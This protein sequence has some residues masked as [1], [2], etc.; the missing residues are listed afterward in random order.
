MRSLKI[1]LT[2]ACLSSLALLAAFW[3]RPVHAAALLPATDL[4]TPSQR[5]ADLSKAEDPSFRKHVIPLLARVGCSAREC[6]GSFQGRGGFQLS[7]FGSEWQ[8][9]LIQLTQKKGGEDEIR[10]DLKNPEKSLILMKPTMQ[11][12]HKGKERFK[13]DSW[14]YNMIL[15]WIQGGIKDD[16]N[17]TGELQRLEISPSEIV[18]NKQGETVQLRVLA[19]WVDGSVEDVT[20]IT[21]F[22]TNDERSE[23][24]T[25]ELQ[26]LA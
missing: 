23:E 12:K 15:K 4:P 21:R 9:D 14:Q 20:E 8:A 25:S 18:F 7:L 2:L 10:V 6:H 5:F 17:T 13:K 22:K 1:T 26:S 24:H 19:H 3:S 11:M 16:S